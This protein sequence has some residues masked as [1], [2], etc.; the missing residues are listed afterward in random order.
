[1]TSRVP[2]TC[3]VD[4][5]LWERFEEHIAE[6]EDGI[7]PGDKPEHL[8]RAIREY[9]DDD[10]L[11]RVE[12]KVDR[13]LEASESAPTPTRGESSG[14]THTSVSDEGTSR[15]VLRCREIASRIHKNHDEVFPHSAVKR[16]IEDIAGGHPQ[17]LEK[18]Q[19]ML[20][21]RQLLFEHPHDNNNVWTVEKSMWA[22]WV[23]NYIGLDPNVGISDFAEQYGMDSDELGDLIAEQEVEA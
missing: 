18:Y 8:E 12:R 14:H 17:T 11:D 3:R 7:S 19:T 13:L 15:T 23:D 1:M 6:A 9:I 20:K 4:E 21:E 5:A 22:R 10:R 2:K 16:A